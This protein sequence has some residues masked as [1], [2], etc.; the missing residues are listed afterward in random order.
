[1]TYSHIGM[2][3]MFRELLAEDGLAVDNEQHEQ[4]HDHA[5]VHSAGPP[6][7]WVVGF[8]EPTNA[9]HVED[10]GNYANE[11]ANDG[12]NRRRDA[13][14]RRHERE[15]DVGEKTANARDDDRL[16]E[17]PLGRGVRLTGFGCLGGHRG[18]VA[19]YAS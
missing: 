16:G 3:G 6:F 14:Q 17:D 19:H 1:M 18:C 10:N 5:Y 9:Q 2:F 15:D 11:N 4:Q 13:D 8:E 12:T 7:V